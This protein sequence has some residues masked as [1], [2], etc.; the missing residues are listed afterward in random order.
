VSVQVN[1]WK[2]SL[3]EYRKDDFKDLLANILSEWNNWELEGFT[4]LTMYLDNYE[5]YGDSENY[6]I[7]NGERDAT[8]EEL[9]TM[10]SEDDIEAFAKE[11]SIAPYEARTVLPLVESGKLAIVQKG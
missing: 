10:K 11:M 5:Q 9:K 6:F 1:S 7:L 2:I 4:N 8:E 3:N